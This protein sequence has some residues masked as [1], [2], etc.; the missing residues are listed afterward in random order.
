MLESMQFP[1]NMLKVSWFS[2][3]RNLGYATSI[4]INNA[5]N[6]TFHRSQTL[7]LSLDLFSTDGDLLA[8]SIEVGQ[9]VRGQRRQVN[10][11]QI[12]T[13]LGI[14]TDVV[15]VLHQTPD[16]FLE[17]PQILFDL[18]TISSWT[19]ASDEFIGYEHISSGLRSG[20]HYQS[21]PMNDSRIPSSTTTIMQSPKVIVSDRIDSWLLCIAPS[22]DQ[23]FKKEIMF[24]LAVLD[25]AGVIHGRKSVTIRARGRALISVKD[26]LVENN[27][28]DDYLKQGGYGMIIGLS[29]NGT[30]I[31]L[32]IALDKDGGLAVDHSLP[33]SYYI[34][35]WGGDSRRNAALHLAA[36]IFPEVTI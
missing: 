33:P 32:A 12:L 5:M 31:P 36:R 27:S 17:L 10:I 20:V 28:L 7:H 34:P 26:I 29:T 30:L 16:E 4:S 2:T 21:P 8:T 35:W 22:S 18:S 14:Q 13:E 6:G 25:T 23:A 11:E 3:L 19:Y 1:S 24:H 15:G 9:L